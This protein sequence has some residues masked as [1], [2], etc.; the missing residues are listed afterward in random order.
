MK[1][2]LLPLL[3]AA[4]MLSGCEN[5]SDLRDDYV[6]EWNAVMSGSVIMSMDSEPIGEYPVTVDEKMAVTKV[7]AT[8]D[9]LDIGGIKCTLK[10]KELIFDDETENATAEGVQTTMTVKRTGTVEKN[11]ITIYETY[12]GSWNMMMLMSG[13][14]NGSTVLT[15]TK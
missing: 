13:T 9:G 6:G 3:L 12:T 2:V 10:G 8:D 5:D 11:K 14:I 1:K 7:T 4:F 15:L